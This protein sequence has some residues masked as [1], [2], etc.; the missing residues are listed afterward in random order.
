MLKSADI[1][2]H[3]TFKNTNAVAL[4]TAPAGGSGALLVYS[5]ASAFAQTWKSD[6]ANGPH[7]NPLFQIHDFV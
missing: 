5:F 7:T 6:K 1:R 4:E 2:A 3:N